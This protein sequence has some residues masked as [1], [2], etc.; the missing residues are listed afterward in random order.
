[1]IDTPQSVSRWTVSTRRPQLGLM[2]HYRTLRG[3]LGSRSCTGQW[4][5]PDQC[6]QSMLTITATVWPDAIMFAL[7]G[8]SLE[9]G[10]VLVQRPTVAEPAV[11]HDQLRLPS[12]S[13]YEH[14]LGGDGLA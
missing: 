12:R 3:I 14:C 2:P 5:H 13:L 4:C 10:L 1:M 6:D 9:Q 7:D 8:W 11:V